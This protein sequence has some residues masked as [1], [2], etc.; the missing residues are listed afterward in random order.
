[1]GGT[2]DFDDPDNW[3]DGGVPG[4]GLARTDDPAV[5]TFS[6]DERN[7]A[8]NFVPVSSMIQDGEYGFGRIE[9]PVHGQL[10]FGINSAFHINDQASGN[11]RYFTG[12]QDPADW[13]Y[14]FSCHRNWQGGTN[15]D[16]PP[17]QNDG[18]IF[19][20]DHTY[21]VAVVGRHHVARMHFSGVEVT[22]NDEIEHVPPHQLFAGNG[23]L[24]VGDSNTCDA[25]GF[26]MYRENGQSFTRT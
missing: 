16:L 19:S 7:G 17:C 3:D 2:T 1:M 11:T 24:R 22:S 6:K 20:S 4:R 13:R 25:D 8:F 5:V 9:F 14:D 18:A 26:I 21:A 23:D 15:P 10:T 12:A